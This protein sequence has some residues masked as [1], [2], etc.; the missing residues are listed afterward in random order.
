MSDQD[1]NKKATFGEKFGIFIGSWFLVLFLGGVIFIISS[2]IT[3]ALG[4]ESKKLMLVHSLIAGTAISFIIVCLLPHKK[5]YFAK[6][7]IWGLRFGLLIYCA[8]FILNVGIYNSTEKDLSI[9]TSLS[10]QLSNARGAI[11]PIATNLGTGTAFAIDEN[12]TYLTAYHVIDGADRIYKNLTSGE[13]LLTVQSIAPEYDIALLKSEKA[14]PIYL[15]LT[16]RYSLADQVYTYGYP[17]NTFSAGSPSVSGGLISRILTNEQLI[18]TDKDIPA[19]LE[20]IQTDAAVNPGN[21]GGPLINECGV[22]GI[23]SA[24]SD[25]NGLQNYGFVSEQGISYAVSSST[26]AAKFKLEILK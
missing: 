25:R 7:C 9:C 21:S 17:G 18:M 26:V 19:G 6:Y 15:S 11:T 5:N 24:M 14:S 1:E 12:G 20:M 4:I 16:S 8:I 13:E 3:A 10:G 22:V 2:L 23:I